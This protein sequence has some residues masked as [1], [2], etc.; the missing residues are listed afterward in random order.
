[1]EFSRQEYWSGLLYPSPGDLPNP[2]IKPRFLALQVNSLPFEHQGSPSEIYLLIK[3]QKLRGLELSLSVLG[4]HWKDWHWSWNSNTLATSCKELTHLKR[5][6]CWERLRAE[7]KGDNRGWDGW[8]ASPTQWTQVWVELVMDREAW[9]AA[10]HGVA[11][12]RTWLSNWTELSL[13]KLCNQF[14]D[15]SS[16]SW[17][18]LSKCV[19]N[20][21]NTG[22]T[23]KQAKVETENSEISL[24]QRNLMSFFFFFGK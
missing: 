12:S 23:S 21:Y 4:V 18:C 3:K 22:C 6:W 1:M 10:V 5:P 14:K 8:M 16:I 24:R 9:C 13:F 19:C 20:I 15:S 2:G 11:K 7:G 17:W